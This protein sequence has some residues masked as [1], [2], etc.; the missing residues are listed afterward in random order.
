MMRIRMPNWLIPLGFL[1]AACGPAGGK[2]TAPTANQRAA[3]AAEEKNNSQIT[4]SPALQPS[5]APAQNSK[6]AVH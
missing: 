2:S 3:A 1:A 4:P 5:M 6:P